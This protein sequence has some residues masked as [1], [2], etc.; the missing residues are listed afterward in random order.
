MRGESRFNLT[1]G[2]VRPWSFVPSSQN[3]IRLSKFPIR[4]SF[5]TPPFQQFSTGVARCFNVWYL[6]PD[7]FVMHDGQDLNILWLFTFSHYDR[8]SI[9]SYIAGR[10]DELV[11]NLCSADIKHLSWTVRSALQG[12]CS[13]VVSCWRFYPCDRRLSRVTWGGNCNAIHARTTTDNWRCT[14]NWIWN[15]NKIVFCLKVEIV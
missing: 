5:K 12:S 6:K 8:K 13:R 4:F 9:S 1:D 10:I 11:G 15:Y 2:Y 14:V 3:W 7:F